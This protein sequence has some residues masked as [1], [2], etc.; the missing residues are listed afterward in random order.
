[1]ERDMDCVFWGKFVTE[2]RRCLPL[3]LHCLDVALVFRELCNLNAIRRSLNC[4]SNT[5][6]TSQQLDR[7]AVLAMFHDVGKANL[8][9]Q[10]KVFDKQAIQAGHIKELAPLL[11]FEAWDE[12][13]NEAFIQALPQELATWFPD[14]SAAYSY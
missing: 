6:L 5:D 8:G 2:S 9:F 3:T 12:D 10:L 13:L 7:L 4:S 1:M 11:D 14:G